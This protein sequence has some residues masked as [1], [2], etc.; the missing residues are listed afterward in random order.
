MKLIETLEEA[1]ERVSKGEHIYLVSF[2]FLGAQGS[3]I[4]VSE[5]EKPLW[6]IYF[7][8]QN[9]NYPGV[10]H[11]RDNNGLIAVTNLI[12]LT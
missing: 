1:E 12:K 11:I 2:M 6:K 4:L 3:F 9:K 5:D 10:E 7:I 8:I